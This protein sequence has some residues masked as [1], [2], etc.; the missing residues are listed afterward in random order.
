VIVAVCV[1]TGSP[2]VAYVTVI[3]SDSP[4]EVPDAGLHESH[5]TL[6]LIVYDSVPPPEFLTVNVCDAAFVP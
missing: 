6:L 5:V 2:D 4:V 1:P 3:V